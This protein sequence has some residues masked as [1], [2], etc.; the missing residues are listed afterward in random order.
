MTYEERSRPNV[1]LPDAL[2]KFP[3]II[4]RLKGKIPILFLDYDGTLTP[5]VSNPE[6]AVLPD[7]TKKVLQQLAGHITIA[8]ISGRDRHNVKSIVDIPNLI[9]AGSHGFDITGPDGLEKQHE[10]G[11][12][13]LP[14]LDEAE[15]RLTERLADIAGVQVERKKYAI[16]VHY[17]NVEK[18]HVQQVK[19][20]VTEEVENHPRLKKG[21]G[22]KIL[23]L[24][25]DFDW[26][27]GKALLWLM[28]EL[29]GESEHLVPIFI[30]DDITDEDAFKAIQGKGIG[31][32]VGAHE[33]DTTATF[34]LKDVDEV[35]RFL[36]QLREYVS[37]GI[38]DTAEK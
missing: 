15:Q 37:G 4:S 34:S 31:I 17:R 36:T 16:A 18:E 35:N 1:D 8:L 23:E 6:N 33:E 5:I 24:K 38:M 28:E 20:A 12:D 19:T 9:Y 21:K 14:E 13:V 7:E 2:D 32:L 27:K 25:P 3:E 26:H 29:G 10:K 30:G 22:K 11:Q